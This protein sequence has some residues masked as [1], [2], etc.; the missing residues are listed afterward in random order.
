MYPLITEIKCDECECLCVCVCISACVAAA[1]D[2]LLPAVR[3][4]LLEDWQ[5]RTTHRKHDKSSSWHYVVLF[6][7]KVMEK[8]PVFLSLH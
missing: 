8:Q 7:K 2:I 1:D 4:K 3:I 5:F 6:L